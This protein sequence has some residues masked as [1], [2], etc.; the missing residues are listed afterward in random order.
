[1]ENNQWLMPQEVTEKEYGK[2]TPVAVVYPAQTPVIGVVVDPK[3]KGAHTYLFRETTGRGPKGNMYITS[4]Q[5]LQFV[6]GIDDE[7]TVPGITSEQLFLALLDRHIKMD[8]VYPSDSN[9]KIIQALETCLQAQ[10]ER[11][12]ERMER[13]VIGTLQV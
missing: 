11:I 7:N 8:V 9:K 13:N 12:D 10:K 6:Y 4:E 2:V 3:Y 5:K 1:M